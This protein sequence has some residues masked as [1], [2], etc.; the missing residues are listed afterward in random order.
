MESS[1]D[2]R[3]VFERLYLSGERNVRRLM[4]QADI[5]E[6]TV[7]N[8]M[9][10][11]DRGE[12]LE[13]NQPKRSPTKFTPMVRRSLGQRLAINPEES[14]AQLAEELKERFGRSFS[15]SGV[16]KTLQAMGLR[17]SVPKSRQLTK[18]NKQSR[19]NFA[20]SNL[21]IDWKRV[22]SFDECYFNLSMSRP[23]VRF[24]SRTSRRLTF[25]PPHQLSRI[26]FSLRRSSHF[27]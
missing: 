24:S 22:W 27:S 2:K 20:R 13:P 4:Q 7:Y 17:S 8:Y 3:I 21:G 11:L 5:S 25:R 19:L 12:N 16:R 18:S 26:G 15:G 9:A 23:S 1:R 10:K 6:R 14:S